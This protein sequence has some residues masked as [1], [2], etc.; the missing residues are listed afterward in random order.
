[1]Q[2]IQEWASL[3]E[4]SDEPVVLDLYADWCEPCK[5]LTP[6]L[7]KAANAQANWKLLKINIDKIPEVANQL[8]IKSVPTVILVANKQFIDAFSGYPD[9]TTLKRF[10]GNIE[11]STDLGFI[12]DKQKENAQLTKLE[13]ARNALM[14]AD[15]SKAVELADQLLKD[16]VDISL[17]PIL[18]L[19]LA[20][21]QVE[22]GNIQAYESTISTLKSKFQKEIDS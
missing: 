9:E 5:K 15:Y 10:F 1:M 11:K 12:Q 7:E 4:S 19:M 16:Q 20:H 17:Q 14:N 18:Y 13:L 8:Q 2:S 6:I 3:V 22:L 21:S